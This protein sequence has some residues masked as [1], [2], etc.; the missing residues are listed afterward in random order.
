M[1]KMEL[2]K[3]LV[4]MN[5]MKGKQQAL[6]TSE[7]DY[8]LPD[9]K[10]DME[11]ILM[12]Q[13]E[14]V[15]DGIHSED[16]QARLQ[17]RLLFDVLYSSAEAETSDKFSGSMNFEEEIPFPELAAGDQLQAFY[18]LEDLSVEMIHSRKLRARAA[19]SFTVSGESLYDAETAVWA[20]AEEEPVE[21]RTEQLGLMELA[22]QRKDTYRIS[23]ELELP[24]NRPNISGIL[25][26]GVE[27]RS[28][29]CRP[30]E[31]KV[32]ISGELALFVL[33]SPE[34]G[35]IPLQW[36]ERTFP[37]DGEL[38]CPGS[39]DGQICQCQIR[40]LHKDVAPKQDYDGEM[41]IIAL[42]AALEVDLRLYQENQVAVLQDLYLPGKILE[43]ERGE[44]HFQNLF[45]HNRAKC[46]ITEKAA[47]PG[48]DKIL[49]ICSCRGMV[50]LDQVVP[51]EDGLRAEGAI[52][53]TVLYLTGDDHAPMRSMEDS[54][55]FSHLIEVRG[56]NPQCE[57]RL[58][59]VLDQL[60]AVM[61]N[62]E[63]LEIKA[64]LDLDTLVL[65]DVS[66]PVVESVTV[67]EIPQEVLEAMPGLVGY[68][69]QPG[70]TLWD[71]AKKFYTTAEQI[72]ETNGLTGEEIR[73]GDRLLIRKKSEIL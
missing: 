62:G 40:V 39:R 38:E 42:E 30:G 67:K 49:Q 33:Y 61:I 27:L 14:V 47:V 64:V 28:T 4:H 7:G 8:N 10:P 52:G 26:S 35:Q 43:I 23:E 5:R 73:G 65:Q 22:V 37:I 56:L 3:R 70:D 71:V 12:R 53:V 50:K 59:P 6:I 32:S 2:K 15:I 54:V 29:E 18:H 68:I 1:E 57:Y 69:V 21:C 13:G 25:W 44:A 36:I 55:P 24:G 66:R 11:R 19:I 41:R 48:E 46:R 72:R 16:G 31:D 34:E 45:L 58:N 60:S 51:E 20:E 9:V 63:E 17:G